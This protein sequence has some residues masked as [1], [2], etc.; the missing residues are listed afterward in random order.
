MHD[1]L[2]GALDAVTAHSDDNENLKWEPSNTAEDAAHKCTCCQYPHTADCG[3]ADERGSAEPV[4]G[5]VDPLALRLFKGSATD[6]TIAIRH[7]PRPG[8][9]PIYTPA[10]D[11]AQRVMAPDLVP[12]G[13]THEA[14]TNLIRV[15]MEQAGYDFNKASAMALNIMHRVAQAAHKAGFT[16]RGER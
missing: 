10:R 7:E 8:D 5:W 2:Q 6:H 9:V 11:A 12:H 4:T 3:K 1:R 16:E 14:A 13:M 15:A